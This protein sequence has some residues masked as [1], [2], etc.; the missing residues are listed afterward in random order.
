MAP[1]HTHD[2]MPSA[3]VEKPWRPADY[4][5]LASLTGGSD[6]KAARKGETLTGAEYAALI[7]HLRERLAASEQ[8]LHDV[9]DELQRTQS[10][11]ETPQRQNAAETVK[12]WRPFQ[13]RVRGHRDIG[14]QG[15]GNASPR[16]PPRT[17]WYWSI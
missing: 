2:W 4:P 11:R 17:I 5:P 12:R 3:G 1:E 7:A 9:L 16:V 8:Q 6:G 14:A 15:L 13:T 10:E